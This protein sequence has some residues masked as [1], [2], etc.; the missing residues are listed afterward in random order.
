MPPTPLV[1]HA[2]W[3][4]AGAG[5]GTPTDVHVLTTQ[6]EAGLSNEVNVGAT[7]GGE[8]ENTWTEPH[9][10][11]THSGSTHAATQAAAEAT[12]AAAL[13]IHDHVGGDG[14]ALDYGT[15]LSNPFYAL[16]FGDGSDGDLHC[17]GSNA[18]VGM[19]RSSSVY[20]M[21]RDVYATSVLVDNGV[22][23]KTDGYRLFV[24]GTLTNNGTIHNSGISATTNTGAAAGGR[25]STAGSQFPG[26]SG[27]NTTGARSNAGNGSTTTLLPTNTQR[28]GA[29]GSGSGGSGGAV[30][31]NT[32]A[33]A[34][35]G[36]I[37]NVWQALSLHTTRS[38]AEFS[39]GTGGGGGGGNST[40]PG[41]GGGASG[42]VCFIAALSIV[43]AGAIEAK[44]GDG[45][46]GP[47]TDTGGGGGG[48]GGILLLI[49]RTL[50]G[51]GTTSVAGGTGGAGNGTGT[52]GGNGDAGLVLQFPV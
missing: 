42:E 15:A 20:T 4:A 49:Y 1:T 39:C 26:G 24:T 45:A 41:G 37:R 32:A 10:K 35:D 11:A 5:A 47:N 13:A 50:A 40:Q 3:V 7:P 6:D 12:A 33:G 25:G 34:F 48:A 36:T 28:G 43:N 29:G 16:L 9:V 51:A 31:D 18:V 46:A 52:A 22:T 44:G 23:V 38:F 2:E 21:T 17:D 14:A 8:L 27:G 30:T 19:S